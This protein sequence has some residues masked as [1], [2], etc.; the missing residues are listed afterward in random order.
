MPGL[1]QADEDQDWNGPENEDEDEVGSPPQATDYSRQQ[2]QGSFTLTGCRCDRSNGQRTLEDCNTGVSIRQFAD[3]TLAGNP[4]I[5]GSKVPDI[6]ALVARHGRL[7]TYTPETVGAVNWQY[8]LAGVSSLDRSDRPDPLQPTNSQMSLERSCLYHTPQ[9]HGVL[10]VERWWDIDAVLMPLHS[11]QAH[12]HG[13]QICYSPRFGSTISSDLHTPVTPAGIRPVNCKHI[14]LFRGVGATGFSTYICFPNLPVAHTR[15]AGRQDILQRCTLTKDEQTYLIDRVVLRAIRA[16]YPSRITNH[17]PRTWR[18]ANDRAYQR[19]RE[20][21]S[22]G[23]RSFQEHTYDLP[24]YL[25][26]DTGKPLE[27][28]WTRICEFLQQGTDARFRGAELV[29][30]TYGCKNRYHSRSFDTLRTLLQQQLA[31]TFDMEHVNL[32]YSIVDLAYEDS[33]TQPSGP[34]GEGPPRPLFAVHRSSCLGAEADRLG[35][36]TQ[37]F[38]WHGTAD[39]AS[40]RVQPRSESALREGGFYFLQAYSTAKDLFASV[41]RSTGLPFEEPGFRGIPFTQATFDQFF[42]DFRSR[43]SLPPS[44]R[45]ILRAL[46]ACIT[47]VHY[48]LRAAVRSHLGTMPRKEAR[49]CWD[50]FMTGEPETDQPALLTGEESTHWPYYILDPTDV[51]AYIRAQT[52]RWL[53]AI[54]AVQSTCPPVAADGQLASSLLEQHAA[55]AVMSCLFDV[56]SLTVNSGQVT[57][58]KRI[59]E[60]QYYRTGE[61]PDDRSGDESDNS[62]SGRSAT[63]GDARRGLALRSSLRQSNLFWLPADLLWWAQLRFDP[64]VLIQTAYGSTYLHSQVRGPTAKV[65]QVFQGLVAQFVDTYIAAGEDDESELEGAAPGIKWHAL[66]PLCES[67]YEL[68]FFGYTNWLLQQL[69]GQD[70]R[71]GGPRLP[72]LDS[73]LVTAEERV[74]AWGLSYDLIRRATGHQPVIGVA[75]SGGGQ[76]APGGFSDFP[77]TWDARVRLLF[78]WDDGF[79]RANWADSRWRRWTRYCY[80]SVQARLGA[81]LAD[82]WIGGIGAASIPYLMILPAYEKGKMYQSVKRPKNISLQLQEARRAAGYTLKWYA[83]QPEDWDPG[84]LADEIPQLEW[85]LIRREKGHDVQNQLER[86][87]RRA[88]ELVTGSRFVHIDNLIAIALEVQEQASEG[89]NEGED[90]GREG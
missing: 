74:G 55:S 82:H 65:V 56:L 24:G 70:A 41:D 46:K 85:Q 27:R 59:A 39:A 68:C 3:E 73:D 42:R 1:G 19:M 32:P 64:A 28:L 13:V 90:E 14:R 62:R 4:T 23:D 22:S 12:R 44:R 57:R 53:Y 33:F 49:V 37:T 71:H 75:R 36:T 26:R 43:Q 77:L 47:R 7:P 50:L 18:E 52:N 80:D 45:R 30:I 89:G 79:E 51:F 40:M 8:L 2:L 5:P 54:C 88:P 78:N 48:G 38:S 69:H 9:G 87:R 17:H 67:L 16:V 76:S 72:Q 63:G 35:A 29:T 61:D 20:N 34:D 60:A 81:T 11:L 15:R 31:D 10:A 58:Y 66:G 6:L 84:M 86:I 25:D 21:V 83:A